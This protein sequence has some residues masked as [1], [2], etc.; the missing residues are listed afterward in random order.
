MS[1][2]QLNGNYLINKYK[3]I[4]FVLISCSIPCICTSRSLKRCKGS[5][6]LMG[7]TPI[8]NRQ[9]REIGV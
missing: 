7:D 5:D 1:R 2:S 6:A 3:K 4:R 8:N 9:G